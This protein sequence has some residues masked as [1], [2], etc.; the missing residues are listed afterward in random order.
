MHNWGSMSYVQAN[1]SCLQVTKE[2]PVQLTFVLLQCTP[3]HVACPEKG[4]KDI[5][6]LVSTMH[7][8]PHFQITLSWAKPWEEGE[9]YLAV[10]W[11]PRKKGPIIGPTFNLVWRRIFS[12]KEHDTV[13]FWLLL[14]PLLLCRPKFCRKKSVFERVFL[15]VPTTRACPLLLLFCARATGQLSNVCY[16]CW[17]SLVI[18][19]GLVV[20]LLLCSA[21]VNSIQIQTFSMKKRKKKYWWSFIPF[22]WH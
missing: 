4:P 21:S 11:Q 7:F 12:I 13:E 3:H 16:L 18:K 15:F 5:L 19:T 9:P 10:A 6:S 8:Y 22:L 2:N 17:R 20:V 14:F 1:L